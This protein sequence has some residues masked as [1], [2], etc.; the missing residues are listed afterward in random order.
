MV[1][2]GDVET[3]LREEQGREILGR[4]SGRAWIEG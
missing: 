1:G 3:V 2:K 4:S